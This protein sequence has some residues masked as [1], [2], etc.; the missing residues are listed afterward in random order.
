MYSSG[1]VLNSPLPGVNRLIE[2][3]FQAQGTHIAAAAVF[4]CSCLGLCI[5]S[6]WF[7]AERWIFSYYKGARRLSDILAKSP[8][9]YHLPI[10][11]AS[12]L[13]QEIQ[14]GTYKMVEW[15]VRV[16]NEV[17][18]DINAAVEGA[19]ER[20]QARVASCADVESRPVSNPRTESSTGIPRLPT[21]PE[22]GPTRM[23]GADGSEKYDED[24]PA[25]NSHNIPLRTRLVNKFRSTPSEVPVSSTNSGPTTTRPPRRIGSTSKP[26]DNLIRSMIVYGKAQRSTEKG[27]AQ[28]KRK[29]TGSTEGSRPH[30]ADFSVPTQ[31][32]TLTNI[33]KRIETTHVMR[34]NQGLV[35]HLQFSPNGKFLA[36]SR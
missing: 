19:R 21:I 7:A 12:W 9:L 8:G 36:T 23:P 20:W 31:H 3:D 26:M 35:S 34:T 5:I 28:P 6:V 17:V 33:L 15:F 24:I 27:A 18:Q 4:A 16:G 25:V 32:G 13:F 2:I 14:H 10:A 1:Q 22:L 30:S 29:R 11:I